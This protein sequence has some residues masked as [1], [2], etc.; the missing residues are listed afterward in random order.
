MRWRSEYNEFQKLF[1]ISSPVLS[2][3]L[4]VVYLI[5]YY[6]LC[7]L[8]VMC[9]C[10]DKIDRLCW[11]N[12]QTLNSNWIYIG[13]M[14]GLWTSIKYQHRIVT[15]ILSCILNSRICSINI[16]CLIWCLLGRNTFSF[17]VFSLTRRQTCGNM[18]AFS[19][20]RYLKHI[21]I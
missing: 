18:V 9:L 2:R 13:M 3:P 19:Y 10:L 12:I 8:C 17:L 11:T 7:L 1:S 16:H 5:S 14:I 6:A 4:F 15:Q 20:S 21:S